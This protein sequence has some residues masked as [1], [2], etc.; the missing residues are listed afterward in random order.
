MRKKTSCWAVGRSIKEVMA[1]GEPSLLAY[2]LG[3][4][5]G[6]TSGKELETWFGL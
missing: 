2:V 1:D 3:Y 5:K 4:G 6:R